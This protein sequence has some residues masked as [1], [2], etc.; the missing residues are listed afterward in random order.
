MQ[1]TKSLCSTLEP[2]G[3]P[4]WQ[5]KSSSGGTTPNTFKATTGATVRSLE[6]PGDVRV[7]G[8]ARCRCG[9]EV[10]LGNDAVIDNLLLWL[11]QLPETT[12]FTEPTSFRT[13]RALVC[14]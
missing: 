13:A 10:R 12:W 3:G 5:F 4:I 7:L 2:L 1:G 8:P 9:T 6:R 14:K 11:N